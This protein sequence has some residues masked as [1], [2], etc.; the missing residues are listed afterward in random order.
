[1]TSKEV[2]DKLDGVGCG[3][4]LAKW[5]QVT[6]HL[7]TGMTH[8]C[9]HPAPH[10]I[11]LSEISRNP[12]AL[13]N[14]RF[15]KKKRKE[16]L[17]GKRPDECNY[18]WKVEDSSNSFSDRVF[19]S[20]ED[21]SLPDFETI[22]NSDWRADFNPRY[23]EVSFSNTCNFKCAYCG[24]QFSS[25]WVEE[26]E[27]HGGYKTVDNYNE[28]EGL[29]A[30]GEMPYKQKDYNPYIEAFWEWW[31]DLFPDLHTFRITG[32]EPLLSK[33]TF[34]VLEYIR[35]NP[36][37]NPNISLSINT[38]LGVPDKLMDKFI[39]LA[40]DLCENNKVREL[41][42][43][44]SIEAQGAQAE[45]TRH[46]LDAV[47]FWE[48]VNK[49]LTELPKVTVNVMATFNALSVF[50]YGE[51]IDTIFELKQRYANKDRYWVTPIQLDT[52]YL[53]WPA[54]LSVKLLEDNHKELIL[55]SAKK[56]LYY[57][58]KEYTHENVGFTN[59]EIQKIKRIYDY[60]IGE[61]DFD[62]EH[63]RGK[64]ARFVTALDERRGTNFLKTF[65]ELKS[66]Y[67][68]YK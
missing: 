8:S 45:Y 15:K 34:K 2:K 19:K 50:T 4:C 9:H 42:V 1:M 11:P 68:K 29:R 39:A 24:P 60:A 5:T 31:P 13:H 26:I 7:G 35:D 47:K 44:T 67:V 32:G 49:V 21:W 30:K 40:K 64:F 62:V 53:R 46:G 59:V 25:K 65:P 17:E 41:I 20:S 16:M 27:K 28:I 38:N 23:V 63:Q 55:E 36:E 33:D 54:H 10:K 18:C 43:F 48:N 61:D 12:S 56:A 66:M 22:K 37:V 51:V 14:S 3:F 52:S 58:M 6:M 57:G